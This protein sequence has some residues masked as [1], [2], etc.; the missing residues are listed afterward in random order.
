MRLRAEQLVTSLSRSG[1]RP[2]YLISGN[3]PLQV[4]ECADILRNHARLDGYHE[5]IVLD[6]GVGFDWD[7]LHNETATA[8]L[9]SSKRIIELRLG[10]NKPGKD[11]GNV[12]V[13]YADKPPADDV[14][15]IT[16]AKLDNQTQKTKWF[17]ALEKAGVFIPVWPIEPGQLPA[18]I[19]N[20]AIV[21]GKKIG[22][23]TAM[24]IAEQVEGNLLAAKQE[25]D[26]LCLCV[27]GDEIILDDVIYTVADSS[28]FDVF[29]LT[30]SALDGDSARAV[31]MLEGLR[32]EGFEPGNIYGPLMWDLRR[33][34]M[35]AFTF[36]QGL[37]LDKAFTD[38]RV[39]DQKLKRAIKTTLQRHR[40]IYLHDLLRQG[41]YIDR[42]VKSSDRELAWN[43]LKTLLML[44]S[45]KPAMPL[46]LAYS[47]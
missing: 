3:E 24:F 19:R 34:C 32:S 25:I 44:I 6:P 9:F 33:V 2:I 14:L 11:G 28:R 45:G 27:K 30:R 37:S 18:W 36:E 31:R 39:W 22:D 4:T 35:I 12:L 46:N 10:N 41:G 29:E 8:S 13:N 15:I 40:L 16:S 26:M 21:K 7:A 47:N 20:R 23:V 5:R 38:H 17:T 43:T 1:L 42:M